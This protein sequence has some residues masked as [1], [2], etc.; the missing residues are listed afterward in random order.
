MAKATNIQQIFDAMPGRFSAEKA[1]DL[2]AVIQFNLTG[3]G[4]GQYYATIGNGQC[5]VTQG[6]AANPT[7]TMSAAAAD[8][9]AI[10]NRELDAMQA[11]MLGKVKIKGD[12][13]VAMKLQSLFQ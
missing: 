8:Y 11:F 10:I 12:I 9:L 3:E 4:G 6:A 5:Q 7:L 2:S 13:S 1:G